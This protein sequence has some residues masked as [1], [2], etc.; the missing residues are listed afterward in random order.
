MHAQEPGLQQKQAQGPFDSADRNM[1]PLAGRPPTGYVSTMPPEGN[2]AVAPYYEA[3]GGPPPSFRPPT[4][5]ISLDYLDKVREELLA[6]DSKVDSLSRERADLHQ[7]YDLYQKASQDVNRYADINNRYQAII[8]QLLPMLTPA[9][10]E[11]VRQD[12]ESIKLLAFNAPPAPSAIPPPDQHIPSNPSRPAPSSSGILPT[13]AASNGYG[14]VDVERKSRGMH[15]KPSSTPQDAY[16]SNADYYGRT[17]SPAPHP[18]IAPPP[19]QYPSNQPPPGITNSAADFTG[20]GAAPPAPSRSPV[21]QGA[22]LLA[23]LNHKEVVCSF[24]M[25]N[26]FNY[27]FTGGKGAVKIWDVSRVRETKSAPLVGTVDC[28]DSYIR[29]TKMTNDG[30]RL[31]VAGE[32]NHMVICDIASSMPRVIGRIETPNV[33]TYALATSND[34]KYVFSCCSDGA[35]KMWDINQKRLVRTLGHHASTVTCCTLTP[36]GHRLITG[37]LDK[38]VKVWDVLG[39]KEIAHL[40]Y[41]TPIYSLGFCPIQP[42]RIAVGLEKSIDIRNISQPSEKRE[43]MGVHQDCVLSVRYAPSGSWFATTGKD[44]KWVCWR[45]SDYGSV[46]EIPESSSILCAEISACGDYLATG[47]GDSVANIYSMIY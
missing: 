46:F 12:M 36:D 27:V 35:V 17:Q 32:V 44:K 10:Q 33:L 43:V 34:S 6:L 45:T 31:I 47:S 19:A 37:S 22:R 30:Q 38:S 4:R 20:Y 15:S 42:P 18:P 16:E 25:T 11:G 7:Y 39:G 23:S 9:V 40:E 29:A 41:P 21:P 24:A 13:S 14:V 3:Y 8:N 28:L 2:G 26:P 1:S 5:L